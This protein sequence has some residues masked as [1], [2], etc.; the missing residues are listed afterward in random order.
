MNV[1]KGLILITF[2]ITISQCFI[3][4]STE[5]KVTRTVTCKGDCYVK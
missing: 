2:L 4:E 5:I 1:L 3:N